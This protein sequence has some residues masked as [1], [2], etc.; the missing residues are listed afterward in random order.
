MISA[1]LK[2]AWKRVYIPKN[3]SPNHF[4]TFIPPKCFRF[5][6]SLGRNSFLKLD[7]PSKSTKIYENISKTCL[8]ASN[9]CISKLMSS[10]RPSRPN[11]AYSVLE[12]LLLAHS[13]SLWICF[14]PI[15]WL[16]SPGPKLHRLQNAKIMKN[17]EKSW[18][19]NK[20]NAHC[21]WLKSEFGPSQIDFKMFLESKNRFSW[22]F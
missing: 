4:E 20:K 16:K 19:H 9:S 17:H 21:T 5:E 10:A 11:K 2:S 14:R 3:D 15:L 12:S 8:F 1:H 13:T 22:S 7:H 6:P 18:N